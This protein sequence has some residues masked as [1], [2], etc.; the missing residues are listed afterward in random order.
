MDDELRRAIGSKRLIRVT[1]KSRT[2]VAE[3]H[4]YGLLNGTVKLLVYQVSGANRTGVDR[5]ILAGGCWRCRRS[6]SW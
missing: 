1:Y 4:D 2:R 6:S 5:A 3:P